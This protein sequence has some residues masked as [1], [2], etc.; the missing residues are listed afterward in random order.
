MSFTHANSAS[1]GAF[2]GVVAFV[3]IGL[4]SGL[5]FV[6]S[7]GLLLPSQAK[8]VTFAVI[9][10]IAL[11]SLLPAS[12]VVESK[13]QLAIP[14]FFGSVIAAAFALSLSPVGRI[15]AQGLPIIA[16]VAF[17]GF[18]LP[19]ELVL[20][21]WA[22]QGTIPETMTWTGQNPDIIA[23]I[24]AII[25]A[26]F[27]LRSRGVAWAANLIG[28]ILLLNVWRVA[29]LSSPVPFGWQVE[30]PLMLAAYLP[31]AWIGSVCVAG[32]IAGHVILTRALLRRG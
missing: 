30:P 4:F 31:Y 28:I 26:P 19:L 1:I 2:L 25:A 21:S 32:A 27:S 20:H 22:S 29:M 9:L 12:G 24:V 8:G 6:R 3:L 13:P 7:R 14:L 5:A 11:S 17:Q 18:R 23:G 15:L 16:L 10:W